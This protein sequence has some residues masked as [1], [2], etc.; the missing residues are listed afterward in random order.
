MYSCGC[1]CCFIFLPLLVSSLSRD[2]QKLTTQEDW[3]TEDRR[4]WSVWA[5]SLTSWWWELG[6]WRL[7]NEP[8]R[9]KLFPYRYTCSHCMYITLHAICRSVCL[10]HSMSVSVSLNFCLS[11]KVIEDYIWHHDWKAHTIS[12]GRCMVIRCLLDKCKAITIVISSLMHVCYFHQS[13]SINHNQ[14]PKWRRWSISC[15]NYCSFKSK[16]SQ[17]NEDHWCA[18]LIL[19][20]ESIRITNPRKLTETYL[21]FV[22]TIKSIVIKLSKFVE[23]R[24]G[25]GMFVNCVERVT[26]DGIRHTAP[27][28]LLI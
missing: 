14:N 16:I 20:M 11:V 4:N 13:C 8:A 2:P 23:N 28:Q 25:E 12:C 22:P 6:E 7:G 26:T 3:I 24:G 18:I 1:R 9:L 17:K 27:F 21:R 5:D 10:C 15:D 19:T